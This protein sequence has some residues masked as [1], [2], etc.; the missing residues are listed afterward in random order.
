ME[1]SQFTETESRRVVSRG[2][3][4]GNRKLVFNGDGVS[5]GEGIRVPKLVGRNCYT[6]TRAHVVPQKCTLKMVNYVYVSPQLKPQI[7]KNQKAGYQSFLFCLFVFFTD[8]CY[9]DHLW[10]K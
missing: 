6:I 8:V 9:R 7:H 1:S 10:R 4:E 3:G 5:V 2:W